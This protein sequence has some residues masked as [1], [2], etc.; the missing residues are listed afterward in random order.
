M[1]FLVDVLK[2]HSKKNRG[3]KRRS[4]IR[5]RK[6]KQ[7]RSNKRR[8]RRS[9]R[10][11]WRQLR[12]SGRQFGQNGRPSRSKIGWRGKVDNNEGVAP[13]V[14]VATE[15]EVAP[16]SEGKTIQMTSCR[17]RKIFSFTVMKEK[18]FLSRS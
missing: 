9:V 3:R 12:K 18:V 17:E 13:A 16:P 5:T 6:G 4:S 7:R 14:V 8:Q 15:V 11:S 10:E 1:K 2:V